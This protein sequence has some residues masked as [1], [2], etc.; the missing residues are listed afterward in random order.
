MRAVRDL[1]SQR[2]DHLFKP[3]RAM[4]PV[5][6]ERT[7]DKLTGGG[8]RAKGNRLKVKAKARGKASGPRCWPSPMTAREMPGGVAP[9]V[10]LEPTF[11]SPAAIRIT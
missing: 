9:L 8:G 1:P 5:S 3:I 10:G 4:L 7:D 6:A 2:A 11:V